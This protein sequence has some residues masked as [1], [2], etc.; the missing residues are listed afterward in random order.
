MN[1][2]VPPRTPN[3][4]VMSAIDHLSIDRSDIHLHRVKR[5]R[6]LPFFLL[7]FATTYFLMSVHGSGTFSQEHLSRTDALYFAVTIFSASP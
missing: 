2:S 1:L 7:L 4:R 6:M 5:D 3:A